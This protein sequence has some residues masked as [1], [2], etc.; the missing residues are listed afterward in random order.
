[1][2]N[3]AENDIILRVDKVSK[4][5]QMGE[6]KVTALNQV[7]LDI[8]EGE[9]IVILGPSGSGKS[10]LLNIIGGMDH[11]SDGR[12]LVRNKEVSRFTDRELTSYRRDH[13]GFVFQFFNLMANLTARENVELATEL[14]EDAL[15]IDE[16]LD[17][18][19]LG[20]R[21]DHFPSQMSGGEQQR[22][23]I[24][25]AI[26]KNPVLLLCDEPTGSLDF[27][28]GIRILSLL[29]KVNEDYKKTVILITHNIAIG[30]MASRVLK[31]RSGEIIE[32]IRNDNPADPEGIEW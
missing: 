25:R 14:T 24:A 5:Y 26:A 11:P 17:A 1:M 32:D 20:E 4:F 23:A 12:I 8:Q 29:K 19:G 22:V 15:D 16:I 6:V 3:Q 28:T 18:V 30:E 27:K 31:M 9:F 21:K 7:S 13:I 2:N 10:T